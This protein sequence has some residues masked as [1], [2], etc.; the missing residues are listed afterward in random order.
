MREIKFRV[1][2]HPE[3][4]MYFRGYQKLSH[5]L[6]CEEDG[7]GGAGRPL[8]R[9]GY[10]DCELLESTGLLDVRGREIYEGDIVLVRSG[11]KSWN[12]EVGAVP[13]MFRSRGL[14]P[15]VSLLASLGLEDGEGL[16]FEVLGN[17]FENPD[18][19]AR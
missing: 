14:H 1:W 9:A 15:L 7:P 10:Q 11:G 3:K 19:L 13:D 6:L 12:G 17:R 5:V 8:K 18:L 16:E 4:R 2:Y